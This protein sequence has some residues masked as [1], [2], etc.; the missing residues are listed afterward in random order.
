MLQ[1]AL[2]K[3]K[4]LIWSRLFLTSPPAPSSEGEGETPLPFG[5]QGR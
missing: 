1:A 3:I 2:L 5:A 4:N